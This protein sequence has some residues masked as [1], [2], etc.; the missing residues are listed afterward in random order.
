MLCRR[1]SRQQT[2]VACRVKRLPR[3]RAKEVPEILSLTDCLPIEMRPYIDIIGV[4]MVMRLEEKPEIAK[5]QLVWG[6]DWPN[7]LDDQ[8]LTLLDIFEKTN[9]ENYLRWIGLIGWMSGKF[10]REPE[11]GYCKHP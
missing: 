4:K 8:E 11:T 9:K 3:R 2:T 5:S 1:L 7:I 6:F 10:G